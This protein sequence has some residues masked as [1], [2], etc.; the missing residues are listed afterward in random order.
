MSLYLQAL[1]PLCLRLKYARV[2][3]GLTGSAVASS[4][5]YSSLLSACSGT[6]A[7]VRESSNSSA[8]SWIS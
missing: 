6:N 5:S 4:P 3:S 2:S 7:R 1:P 8:V